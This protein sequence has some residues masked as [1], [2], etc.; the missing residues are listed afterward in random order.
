MRCGYSKLPLR[1]TGQDDGVGTV[2]GGRVVEV[3]GGAG[4]GGDGGGQ[5]PQESAPRAIGT[6]P[7]WPDGADV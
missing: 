1:L 5:E 4:G 6:Q 7:C 2:G 3:A